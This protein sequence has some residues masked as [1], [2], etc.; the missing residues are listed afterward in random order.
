MSVERNVYFL[1]LDIRIWAPILVYQYENPS[2]YII[3]RIDELKTL[4]TPQLL[5]YE[6]VMILF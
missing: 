6:P 4:L 2:G 3:A 5:Q 1:F